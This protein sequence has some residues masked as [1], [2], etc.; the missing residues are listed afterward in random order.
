MPA[1]SAVLAA[2]SEKPARVITLPFSCWAR[3]WPD[4]PSGDIEVG[5]RVPPEGVL[6]SA[7]AEA[8]RQAWRAHPEE[9]DEEGRMEA[10]N[11]AVMSIALAHG[12]TEPDDA[13]LPYFGE[14]AVDNVPLALTAAGVEYLYAALD[15]LSIEESVTGREVGPGDVAAL[16]AALQ[17]G[18]LWMGLEAGTVARVR[19]LLAHLYDVCGVGGEG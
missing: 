12:V 9:G 15:L 5:L 18:A 16:V 13:R 10:Y 4:I 6:V 17:S 2:A 3:A 8:A 7:R 11:S 1:F 14:M 19:R